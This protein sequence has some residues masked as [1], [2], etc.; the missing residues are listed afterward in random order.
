MYQQ[1][2]LRGSFI[3]VEYTVNANRNVIRYFSYNKQKKMQFLLQ[4][5]AFYLFRK[6]KLNIL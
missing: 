4:I 3:L 5:S 2:Q 1:D 6:G